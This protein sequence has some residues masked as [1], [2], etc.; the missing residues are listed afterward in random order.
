MLSI[1]FGRNIDPVGQRWKGRLAMTHAIDDAH[2]F[3]IGAEAGAQWAES[4]DDATASRFIGVAVV[5][6]KPA[7]LMENDAEAALLALRL[8]RAIL[9]RSNID[10]DTVVGFWSELMPANATG[11]SPAFL[12]GFVSAAADVLCER[13]DDEYGEFH[14]LA[15]A[16]AMAN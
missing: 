2:D 3:A 8:T 6:G 16:P 4:C 12:Q 14:K 5:N 11:L 15:I 9:D 1:S 10:A 7:P 13:S